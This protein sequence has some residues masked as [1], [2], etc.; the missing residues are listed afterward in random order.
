M[1][2][3]DEYP[4]HDDDIHEDAGAL[5]GIDVDDGNVPNNIVDVDAG[6]TSGGVTAT[7]GACSIDTHGTSSSGKHKSSV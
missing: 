7:T 3:A 4:L 2:G 5:F 1:A 6:D